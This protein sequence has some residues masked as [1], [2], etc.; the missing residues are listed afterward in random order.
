M[1]LIS[2]RGNING[3]NELYENEPSYINSALDE[4][5]DVE[6]DVWLKNE[7]WFLGHDIPQY[8]INYN[9]LNDRK[10]SLWVHCKNIEAVVNLHS[11][12]MHYFWHENDKITLTSKNYI[13]AFPSENKIKESIDVLPERYPNIIS[14]CLGVCSDYIANFKY[15]IYSK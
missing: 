7:K 5:Y 1:I 14:N 2:H 15:N 13:W 11:K 10:D 9:W 12:D 3:K 6:I 8:E 4:G